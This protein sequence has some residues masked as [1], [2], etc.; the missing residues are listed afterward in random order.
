MLDRLTAR[1][2]QRLGRRYSFVFPVAEDPMSLGVAA[3]T[4]LLVT[5][6]YDPSG[7]ELAL[8]VGAGMVSTLV[9]IGFAFWRG[10]PYLERVHAWQEAAEPGEEDSALAWDAATNFPMR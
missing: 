6:Y 9:A 4:V 5:S 10:Q 2:Y 8:M 3:I 7:G 1:L